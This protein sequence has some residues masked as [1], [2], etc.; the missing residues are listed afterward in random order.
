MY[1]HVFSIILEIVFSSIGKCYFVFGFVCDFVSTF[2]GFGK[3]S[4]LAVKSSPGRQS[5]SRYDS[6]S[7]YIHPSSQ[8]YNDIPCETDEQIED[9]LALVDEGMLFFKS[10]TLSLQCL[11]YQDYLT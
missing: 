1:F 9:G 11:E 7:C 3:A 4:A 5:K 2:S 6:I 10:G 8:A